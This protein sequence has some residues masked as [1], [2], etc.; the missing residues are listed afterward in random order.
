[1]GS[2]RMDHA[3]EGS[4]CRISCMLLASYDIVELTR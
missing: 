3:M 4:C 2:R 1:M